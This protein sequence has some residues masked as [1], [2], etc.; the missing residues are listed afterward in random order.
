MKIRI[1]TKTDSGYRGEME[2]EGTEEEIKEI[3]EELKKEKN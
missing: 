3:L 2:V 1:P